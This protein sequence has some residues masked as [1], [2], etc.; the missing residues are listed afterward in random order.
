MLSPCY[1]N[2]NE[3]LKIVA[4]LDCIKRGNK[5]LAHN[6]TFVKHSNYNITNDVEENIEYIAGSRLLN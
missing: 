1:F 2:F 4:H 5:T 6:I 3:F